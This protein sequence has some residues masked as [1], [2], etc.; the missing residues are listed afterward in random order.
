VTRALV[1]YIKTNNLVNKDNSKIISP[2]DKLKLLLG[3][4]ESDVLNYFNI[5]KFMNKHFI[6]EAS[7]LLVV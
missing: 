2:D 3:V 6:D 4:D 5:K 1:S 7:A